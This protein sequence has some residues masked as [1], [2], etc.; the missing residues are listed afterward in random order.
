MQLDRIGV[1][2]GEAVDAQQET[3]N[4]T[5]A[6]E[7]PSARTGD[8]GADDGIVH[9]GKHG[10]QTPAGTTGPD[11][12]TSNPPGRAGTGADAH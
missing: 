2:E 4:R 3:R 1:F 5:Q 10:G 9:A 11:Q 6:R 7:R 8:G 12:A